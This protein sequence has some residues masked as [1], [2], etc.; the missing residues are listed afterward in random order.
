MAATPTTSSAFQVP[1]MSRALKLRT[2]THSPPFKEKVK[3]QPKKTAINFINFK[4]SKFIFEMESLN[5]F[6]YVAVG[7]ST[8]KLMNEDS[9]MECVKK[10]DKIELYSS[11]TGQIKRNK[12]ASRD[13]V[14]RTEIYR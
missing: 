8:D 13:G 3:N 10:G 5:N 14:V 7:L 2:A 6:A 4:G 12:I 9:S 1:T 11:L